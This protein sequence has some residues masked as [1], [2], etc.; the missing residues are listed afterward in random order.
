[1]PASARGQAPDACDARLRSRLRRL[2]KPLACRLL[3]L[4]G[5]VPGD[6][7]G[8]DHPYMINSAVMDLTT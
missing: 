5:K 3:P 2:N 6:P 7:T 8:F 4:P 1:L